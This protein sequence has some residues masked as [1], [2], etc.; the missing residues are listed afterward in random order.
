M[1]DSSIP[2]Q[3][4]ET[5]QTA[6][7]NRAPSPRH[8]LNPST[9]SSTYEPVEAVEATK[10]APPAAEEASVHITASSSVSQSGVLLEHEHAQDD[11]HHNIITEDE[12]GVDEDIPL[13]VLRP[14]P[15]RSAGGKSSKSGH[16]HHVHRG[17]HSIAHLLHQAGGQHGGRGLHL[18]LPGKGGASGGGEGTKFP[19]M[20]DLRFEQSYLRSVGAALEE[21]RWGRVAWITARDQVIMPLAQGLLYNLA[22]CGW[23]HWNRAARFGGA[24][25]GARLRRWWYGVNNWPLPKGARA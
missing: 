19:P 16:G 10:T 3:I 12:D 21:G 1:A 7:I 9:A 5:I 23:Q 4:A 14:L 11:E 18:H 17:H 15:R 25:L 22:L 24:S 8:D 20:P 2:T 6:S 13:S